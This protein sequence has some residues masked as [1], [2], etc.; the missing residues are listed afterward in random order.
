MPASVVEAFLREAELN[1]RCPGLCALGISWQTAQN[2][3]L[4]RSLGL[5][6]AEGILITKA[7]GSVKGVLE[8]GDV[9]T[10]V[11]GAP[12]ADD[13]TIQL[14]GAERVHICVEIKFRAPHAIDALSP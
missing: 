3:A 7:G 9:V 1:E 10:N 5:R 11:A 14:R 2:K 8:P 6:G 4:R 12:V 13:G